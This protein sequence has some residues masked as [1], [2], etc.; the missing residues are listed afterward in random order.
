[1][2]NFRIWVK[3]YDSELHEALRDRLLTDERTALDTAV[4][5]YAR[6]YLPEIGTASAQDM[7]VTPYDGMR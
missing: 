2:Q 7:P 5:A 3:T 6:R 4:I 1:M